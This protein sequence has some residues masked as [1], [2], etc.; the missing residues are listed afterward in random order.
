MIKVSH[1][2]KLFYL[3][4]PIKFLKSMFFTL[5]M[6]QL[7]ISADNK[8]TIYLLMMPLITIFKGNLITTY[9]IYLQSKNNRSVQVTTRDNN[10]NCCFNK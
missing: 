10:N 4:C 1:T 8:A 5:V 2:Y 7:T 3:S 9:I 6:N